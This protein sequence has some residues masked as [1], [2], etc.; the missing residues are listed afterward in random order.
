MVVTVTV[1]KKVRKVKEE[2]VYLFPRPVFSSQIPPPPVAFPISGTVG[3]PLADTNFSATREIA[4]GGGSQKAQGSVICPIAD[5]FPGRLTHN[6]QQFTSP[7]AA[8]LRLGLGFVPP[9]KP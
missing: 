8:L 4:S 9:T 1:T 6:G 5:L 2:I 7:V 3:K